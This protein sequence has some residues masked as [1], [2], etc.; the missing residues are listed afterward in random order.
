MGFS[1]IPPKP[2][3][4][5]AVKS[6]EI[7][8]KRAD[9]AIMHLDVPWALLLAGASPED[10]L[11]KDRARSEKTESISSITTDRSISSSW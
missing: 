4:K 7:W 2:D 11:R 5:I 9:A 1:V 10:A 8:T 3:L 6:L